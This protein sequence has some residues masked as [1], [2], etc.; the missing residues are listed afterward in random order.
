METSVDSWG[1]MFNASKCYIVPKNRGHNRLSHM[2]EL[3]DTFLGGVTKE[4]YLGVVVSH[5]LSWS[6]HINKLTNTAHAKTWV[7]HEKLEGV[8]KRTEE[9]CLHDSGKVW[10]KPP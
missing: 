7:S 9:D 3:C 6:S 2:Y 4:K 8:S 5:D 1:L 10:N